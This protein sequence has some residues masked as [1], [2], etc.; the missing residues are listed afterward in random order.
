MTN[1][2]KADD[3]ELVCYCKKTKKKTIK[4]AI[5]K[6][7]DSLKKIKKITKAGT[8]SKCKK[9]NPSKKSCCKDIKTLIKLYT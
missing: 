4:K 6:G 1:W 8:G 3:D 7:S 9:V 2:K 5:Q